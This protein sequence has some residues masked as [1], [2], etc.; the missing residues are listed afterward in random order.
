[1]VNNFYTAGEGQLRPTNFRLASYFLIL[2]VISLFGNIAMGIGFSVCGSR[3]TRKM[4]VLSFEAIDMRTT[5]WFDYLECS[6][7]ELTSRFVAQ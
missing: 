3:L 5:S 7:S 2:A 4:R 6:T 1:M